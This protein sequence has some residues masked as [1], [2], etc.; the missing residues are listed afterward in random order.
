MLGDGRLEREEGKETGGRGSKNRALT[1]N[2]LIN[3]ASI[4]SK[5]AGERGV[6][7]RSIRKVSETTLRKYKG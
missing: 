4:K 2:R 3:E 5:Q 7:A 6:S 1:R